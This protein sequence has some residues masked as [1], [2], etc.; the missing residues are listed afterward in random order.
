MDKKKRQYL[1]NSNLSNGHKPYRVNNKILKTSSS[2][3]NKKSSVLF[4]QLPSEEIPAEETPI[5]EAPLD[6]IPT[7][8]IP[9]EEYLE[10]FPVE[11]GYVSVSVFTALGALPVSNAVVIIYTLNDDNEE[12]V[13]YNLITNAN[14]KV[15]TMELPVVYNPS[16]P[17][18]SSEYYFSTYNL[19]V[20]ATNYYDFNVLGIRIF[21]DITTSYKVDL[22]PVAAGDT[23]EARPSQTFFIPPSPID[24]SND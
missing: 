9:I 21:P 10:T 20:Q 24:I 18:E 2:K 3:E 12:V 17:L 6:E 5:E 11:T 23:S 22:V 13:L 15:P 7:E 1:D 16:D 14:G 19:R 4:Q 8:D